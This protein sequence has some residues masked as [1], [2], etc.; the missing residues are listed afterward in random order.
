MPIFLPV[1]TFHTPCEGCR[2]RGQLARPFCA[3]PT[4]NALRPVEPE[5]ITLPNRMVIVR[6]AS[7][8]RVGLTLLCLFAMLPLRA[9]E[10]TLTPD[11]LP[12]PGV[13]QGEVTHYTFS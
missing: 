1:I 11:S 3:R 8:L 9:D 13:P 4:G 10:N 7:L 5:A 6:T 2:V 12:Q